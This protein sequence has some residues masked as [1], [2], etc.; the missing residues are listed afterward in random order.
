MYVLDT[1]RKAMMTH[2][3]NEVKQELQRAGNSLQELLMQPDILDRLNV[4]TAWTLVHGVDAS[5][6]VL[7]QTIRS[8][9]RSDEPVDSDVTRT[10]RDVQ[11]AMTTLRTT[12]G[13]IVPFVESK[14][15]MP[16]KG[17]QW[18]IDPPTVED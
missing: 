1:L 11:A 10:L 17:T 16:P 4:H 12:L 14:F 6:N 2:K 5:L 9:L 7:E 8:A 18:N 3:V 15:D 13:S